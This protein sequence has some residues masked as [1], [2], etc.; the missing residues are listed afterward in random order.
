M[1]SPMLHGDL[2][3]KHQAMP[4]TN[5][6][7]KSQGPKKSHPLK[8]LSGSQKQLQGQQATTFDGCPIPRTGSWMEPSQHWLWLTALTTYIHRNL[9]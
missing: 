3:L 8:Y 1:A 5:S 9:C 4:S 2:T 6:S 7:S